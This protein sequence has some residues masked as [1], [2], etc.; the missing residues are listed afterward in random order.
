[1]E[2]ACEMYVD[3]K[4]NYLMCVSH[5]KVKSLVYPNDLMRNAA[6]GHYTKEHKDK[7]R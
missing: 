4:A 5:G 2:R 6:I 7:Y 3:D 1:M